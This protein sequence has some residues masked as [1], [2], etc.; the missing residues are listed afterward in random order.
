[1][2]IELFTQ[3]ILGFPRI[4][5]GDWLLPCPGHCPTAGIQESGAE[6]CRNSVMTSKRVRFLLK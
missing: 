5:S 3:S 1:M 4:S 2:F 6:A